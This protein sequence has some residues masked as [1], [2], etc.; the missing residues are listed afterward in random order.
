[1]LRLW[2]YSLGLLVLASVRPSVARSL[3]AEDESDEGTTEVEFAAAEGDSSGYFGCG[4]QTR[5]RYVQAAVQ[6][7]H[8]GGKR[9]SPRGGMTVVLGGAVEGARERVV[10]APKLEDDRELGTSWLEG[11]GGGHLRV[12]Y[13]NR[14][15]GLEGGGG[16][17]WADSAMTLYPSAELSLGV[18]DHVWIFG[19]VGASQLT[20]QLAYAQPF[21]VVGARPAPWL[22]VQA[23]WGLYVW[24]MRGTAEDRIDL[25]WHVR[26]SPRWALRGGL[27]LG[28]LGVALPISREASLGFEYVP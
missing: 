21:L 11:R 12:G 28:Q 22:R 6:I 18:R 3:D 26:M 14:Y 20:T 19:G 25:V 4:Q 27:A 8:T 5:V 2:G 9:N 7:R 13:R 24:G 10:E 16:A 17:V 15:F 1:M 23:L